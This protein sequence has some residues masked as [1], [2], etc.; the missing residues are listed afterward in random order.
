MIK[1]LQT[2]D[3]IS[4]ALM[5]IFGIVI[6]LL[7]WGGEVCGSNCF[8]HTG[9]QVRNFSWQNR[10]IGAEDT[11]FTLTFDRSM[12]REGIAENLTIAP[13]LPGKISW[14][15]KRLAYTLE[16][17]APYGEVYR[18]EL[19]GAR[20]H[21]SGEREPGVMQPFMGQFS[22]R[23]RAFAYI[24][25][26]GDEQGRLILYNLTRKRETVLTPPGLVVLDFQFYPKGE[27]ILFSATE[28]GDTLGLP[29]LYT[30]TTGLDSVDVKLILDS[31]NYQNSHF[32]LAKDGQTIVVGRVN[33]R[34]PA[35]FGLWVLKP[36]KKPQPLATSGGEFLIAPDSQTLAIAQG[37]GVGLLSLEPGSKP[38]D[39]LPQFGRVLSFSS[40]GSAAAMVNFNQNNPELLYTRSLFYV[41]NQ[42]VQKELAN[43]QGSI[44]DCQFNPN[45]TQLYCLLTER[46]E[47]P[48]YQE[49]PYL[50]QIDVETSE[51][52]PL[53]KLP[54]AQ[55]IHISVA[56]DGLGLL[57]DQ[58]ATSV[59]V[60][61]DDALRTDSGEVIVGSR[62]WLLIVPSTSFD[63][64]NEPQLEPLPLLG[65]H[66]Q[67]LP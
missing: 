61:P 55:D 62:L 13:P 59:A 57:F 52:M 11:A 20:E 35:D 10:Q 66:P 14:A 39:F 60:N 30:V 56:P 18:V 3:Q 6:A 23:D 31:Q 2:V 67:W 37:E 25:S 17:P 47:G 26:E 38:L 46:L 40:D 29:N 15:G 58:V 12:E 24:G 21:F 44:I 22:S 53:L 33:R 5:V 50:A 32:D 28:H 49:Q 16:T 9:P 27:R 19:Q 64:S 54:S 51:F 65:I 41:N 36:G 63:D 7:I 8:L 43:I 42:G 1:P 4:L 45:A 34:N 48:E